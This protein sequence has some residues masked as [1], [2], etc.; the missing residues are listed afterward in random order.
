MNVGNDNNMGKNSNHLQDTEL[1]KNNKG[2]LS[3]EYKYY[4]FNFVYI[5]ALQYIKFNISIKK[6]HIAAIKLINRLIYFMQSF[7]LIYFNL[8]TK[9]NLNFDW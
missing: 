8:W 4:F 5:C 2:V 1:Y 3:S 6:T 7:S 9:F